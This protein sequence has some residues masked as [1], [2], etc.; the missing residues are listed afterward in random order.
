MPEAR[1]V[2]QYLIESQGLSERRACRLLNMSRSNYNYQ[3]KWKT[4]DVLAELRKL[5][6]ANPR[7]GSPRLTA[8]L[9]RNGIKVNHKRIA[10][11]CRLEGLTLKRARKRRKVIVREY[12]RVEPATSPNMIWGMDFVMDRTK[13]GSS[14]RSL[15]IVDHYSREC[16]GI[17]VQRSMRSSDVIEFLTKLSLKRQLPNSLSLDNG[18]EF[19]SNEFTKWCNERR[20][21]LS[22]IQPGRPVQN[23]YVESFNSRFRDECLNQRA[24]RDIYHAKEKIEEWRINYNTQRPHSSLGYRTPEEACST[25]E[26]GSKSNELSNKLVLK[27]G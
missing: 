1:Q 21:T 18:P 16:P 14:F 2:V 27:M 7:Y 17:Y 22:Y 12:P 19:T 8:L 23:P 6:K 26:G 10:R 13:G 9:R 20:I 11:L 4:S 3:A 25:K 5:S 24:F 15:T